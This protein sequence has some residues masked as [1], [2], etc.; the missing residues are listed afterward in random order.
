[1]ESWQH[2]QRRWGLLPGS[3]G[4]GRRVPGQSRK[5][6]ALGIL[7][8]NGCRDAVVQ[9]THFMVLTRGF[10]PTD[11]REEALERAEGDPR[12]CLRMQSLFQCH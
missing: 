8:L 5:T 3:E 11:S 4:R 7:E 2:M 1:M 9:E 10:G 12:M 6:N